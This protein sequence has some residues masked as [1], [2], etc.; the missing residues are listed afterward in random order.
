MKTLARI[1]GGALA[2]YAIRLL[3]TAAMP[4]A[5]TALS[6]WKSGTSASGPKYTQGVQAGKSWT[7]GYIAAEPAMAA[8]IQAALAAGRFTAGVNALGDTGY[9]NATVAKAG[10]WMTGVN[11]QQAANNFLQGY[12]IVQQVVGAGLNAIASL[13]SG[14]YADRRARANA[15]M[16]AAHAQS[17]ALKGY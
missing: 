16:D 10:N 3:S 1:V 13:P 17:Q 5:N 9:K 11:T 6:R 15:Y 7:A 8:A 14:S 2:A 4:D 12:Q